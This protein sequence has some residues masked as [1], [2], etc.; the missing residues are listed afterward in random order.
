M[1]LKSLRKNCL[2]LTADNTV[3]T[4]LS[5]DRSHPCGPTVQ[6]AP[7]DPNT[8][9]VTA[10][11]DLPILMSEITDHSTHSQKSR[12]EF[13]HRYCEVDPL[14]GHSRVSVI[15]WMAR[16]GWTHGEIVLTLLSLLGENAPADGTVKKQRYMSKLDHMTAA[17]PSNNLRKKL[18]KIRGALV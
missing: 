16:E 6:A 18:Q 10:E 8:G 12:N 9:T 2:I 3:Y 17:N 11:P 14:E 5:V 4:V 13:R 1:N 7:I 15:R